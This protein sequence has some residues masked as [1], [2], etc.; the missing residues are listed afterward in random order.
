MLWI[1]VCVATGM[2]GGKLAAIE[3]RSPYL[4][5][6]ATGALT[7]FVSGLLGAWF[8]V[9]P[10]LTL[11]GC[12]AGLWIAKSRDDAGGRGGGKIVR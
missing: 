7:Y 9:A 8:G 2:V 6:A 11:A 1:M 5:G 3:N 4:W 12:F 10:L